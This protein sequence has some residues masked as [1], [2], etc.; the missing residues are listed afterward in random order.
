MERSRWSR[1]VGVQEGEG[2]QGGSPNAYGGAG[3]PEPTEGRSP[4]G[5]PP[6]TIH[7]RPRETRAVGIPIFYPSISRFRGIAQGG[8]FECVTTAPSTERVP[9][10]I[11]QGCDELVVTARDQ[12]HLVSFILVRPSAIRLHLTDQAASG[13]TTTASTD[14]RS[15]PRPNSVLCPASPSS[16]R[17]AP[18]SGQIASGDERFR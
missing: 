13:D 1:A 11:T 18:T 7:W 14:S 4:G 10:G 16:G 9:T 12:R 3:C 5:R 8:A 6:A 15:P 17:T 2:D